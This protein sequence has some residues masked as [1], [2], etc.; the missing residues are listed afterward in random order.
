M[1]GGGDLE[2]RLRCLLTARHLTNETILIAILLRQ[3]RESHLLVQ[4]LTGP[5]WS[6][7]CPKANRKNTKLT[8][9]ISLSF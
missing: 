4:A 3:L 9:P 8:M 5:N 6:F 7:E 1:F 2:Q